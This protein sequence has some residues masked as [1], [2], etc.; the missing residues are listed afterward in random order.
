MEWLIH[1]KV[2]FTNILLGF[3]GFKIHCLLC[4]SFKEQAIESGMGRQ[5][6]RLSSSYILHTQD[7][8]VVVLS[9]LVQNLSAH[10]NFKTLPISSPHLLF[11]STAKPRRKVLHETDHQ[12]HFSCFKNS[13]LKSWYYFRNDTVLWLFAFTPTDRADRCVLLVSLRKVWHYCW[14]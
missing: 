1:T 7:I 6:C 13:V 8:S 4:F 12:K 3:L 9:V 14:C 2:P 10:W 11:M 5:S